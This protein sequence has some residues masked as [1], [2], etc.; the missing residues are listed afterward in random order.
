MVKKT[1]PKKRVPDTTSP[2]SGR[3]DSGALIGNSMSPIKE[4]PAPAPKEQLRSFSDK[5]APLRKVKFPTQQGGKIKVREGDVEEELTREEWDNFVNIQS[6]KGG[7]PTPAMNRLL[8]SQEAMREAK[9]FEKEVSAKVR[10]EKINKEVSARLNA[11]E[12]I[13]ERPLFEPEPLGPDIVPGGFDALDAVKVGSAAVTA[14]G[15][16]SAVGTPLLGVGA[17]AVAATTTFFYTSASDRKQQTKVSFAKFTDAT[18]QI[19]NIVNDVNAQNYSPA[20]AR[21]NWDNEYQ[22]VLQAQRELKAQQEAMFGEKLS[23]SLDEQTKL[24][25]WLRRY[26]QMNFDF[27]QAIAA[28]DPNRITSGIAVPGEVNLNE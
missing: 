22:R 25:A 7:Q 18:K 10:G 21:L 6:G 4:P 14:F 16:G 20:Q 5:K 19:E 28:P 9:E 13:G 12:T 1:T 2:N 11:S 3:T 8:A 15:L 26:A 17:A 23:K 27:E 24:E